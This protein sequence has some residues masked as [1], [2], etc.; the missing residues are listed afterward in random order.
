MSQKKIML[1]TDAISSSVLYFGFDLDS[2]KYIVIFKNG[3]EATPSTAYTYTMSENND[4]VKLVDQEQ[5]IGKYVDKYLKS[6]NM[7]LKEE[8]NS[9]KNNEISFASKILNK[10]RIVTP[11]DIGNLILAINQFLKENKQDTRVV[12]FIPDIDDGI[13]R[14]YAW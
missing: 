13:F 14:S 12:S 6:T 5:S 11:S 3:K 1:N 4:I 8:I 10:I 9:L 7:F 2:N